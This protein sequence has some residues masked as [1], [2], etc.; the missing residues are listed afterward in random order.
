[1]KKLLAILQASPAKVSPGRSTRFSAVIVGLGLS[2][3]W[4]VVEGVALFTQF[5]WWSI[6][7]MFAV[8]VLLTLGLFVLFNIAVLKDLKPA[9]NFGALLAGIALAVFIT[10]CRWTVYTVTDPTW[11]DYAPLNPLAEFANGNGVHQDTLFHVA[12]IQSIM[13]FGY[14]STAQHGV[15]L[16]PYH[17]LSHYIDAGVLG[18]TGLHPLDAYG[19][20]FFTK[21]YVFVVA[22]VMFC[23]AVFRKN[24]SLIF[25]GALLFVVPALL[26]NW[27]WIGSEGLWFTTILV[28]LSAPWLFRILSATVITWPQWSWL[29][30]LVIAVGFGKVS[31]GFSLAIFVGLL[32]LL[33]HL[34]DVRTYAVGALWVF[35]YFVFSFAQNTGQ[36]GGVKLPHLSGI[37]GFLNPW[38]IYP[39]GPVEWKLVVLYGLMLVLLAMFVWGHSRSALHLLIASAISLGVLSVMVQLPAPDGLTQPD[40]EY[41]V[42]GLYLP[43]LL[44]TLLVGARLLRSEDTQSQVKTS[45]RVSIGVGMA[46][47]LVLSPHPELW[48]ARPLDPTSASVDVTRVTDF[49]DAIQREMAIGGMSPSN[50]YLVIPSRVFDTEVSRWTSAP[51]A[52]GLA[53]Y[54]LTGVPL[55]HGITEPS[56]VDFG[57]S[58]YDVK[59]RALP[60]P[61]ERITSLCVQGKNVLVVNSVVPPSIISPCN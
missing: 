24:N 14:P 36:T 30:V 22:A 9:V 23:W 41:F 43:V 56:Q 17:V 53:V 16:L 20:L 29:T 11:L 46:L 52:D 42:L 48:K 18:I 8:T 54:A 7:A 55:L 6:V 59:A 25:C 10:L 3:A 15:P 47:L 49:R 28:V 34:R 5:P 61:L 39:D 38:T 33:R 45:V 12:L 13:N 58:L 2:L 4:A 51:W 1:M 50:T 37:F 21:S 44:F 26:S 32:L 40:I 31:S 57:Q 19:L 27:I 35:F 60:R